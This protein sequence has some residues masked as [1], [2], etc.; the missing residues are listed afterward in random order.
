[1]NRGQKDKKDRRRE[2]SR[3]VEGGRAKVVI[4]KEYEAETSWKGSAELQ[5]CVS[6]QGKL[7]TTELQV[8]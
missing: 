5:L 1:M 4:C 2:K 6:M 7:G 8:R 3:A